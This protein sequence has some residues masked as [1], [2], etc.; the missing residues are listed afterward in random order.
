VNKTDPRVSFAKEHRRIA[1]RHICIP[2]APVHQ[3]A[4]PL[5]AL[6]SQLVFGAGFDVYAEEGEWAWGQ[7]VQSDKAGYVGYVPK[8]ALASS[9]PKPTHR[10]NVL[11]A[12]VF[13]RPDLK[14]PIRY[15]LPLN[16][17]VCIERS[18][19]KYHDASGLGYLHDHHIL[20][21]TKHGGDFVSVAELHL[22]LPY[23]WGGVSTDGLDCSGLLQSALRAIGRVAPRDSDMQ[24][25]ALGKPIKYAEDLSG[26]KRGDLL[27]WKRHVGIMTDPET[28]LHANA[29]HM[30]VAR[31]PLNEATRRIEKTAGPITS[32]KRM[33]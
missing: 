29:Y 17:K 10:V 2:I 4:D 31:E 25:Q 14:S 24:E 8:V 30:A 7:E 18:K 11:K 27:F 28:L 32:I 13:T 26:L 6:D 3:K 16:S 23:I 15:L 21:N 12:P 19:G 22:G 1:R 20:S 33:A 5:S 9:V